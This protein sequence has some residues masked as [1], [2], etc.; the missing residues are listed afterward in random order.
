MVAIPKIFHGLRLGPDVCGGGEST[1]SSRLLDVPTSFAVRE[2]QRPRR[3]GCARLAST[4]NPKPD[5]VSKTAAVPKNPCSPVGR[6]TYCPS[7]CGPADGAPTPRMGAILR[8]LGLGQIPTRC[9]DYR[10]LHLDRYRV[11]LNGI[12]GIPCAPALGVSWGFALAVGVTGSRTG[13]WRLRIAAPDPSPPSRICSV[14]TSGQIIC[15]LY[16]KLYT[17]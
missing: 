4:Q 2:M 13:H 5:S 11:L 10:A 9:R 7:G 3:A 16:R 14:Q 8:V 15:I 1:R 6:A 12:S 17:I